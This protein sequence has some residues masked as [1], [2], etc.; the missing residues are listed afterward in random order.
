MFAL[1]EKNALAVTVNKK[2]REGLADLR[3]IVELVQASGYTSKRIQADFTV[4]RGLEYYTGPVF[5]AE[6]LSP[7]KDERGQPIR[8]GSVVSGGRYDGLVERFTGEKV[9]STGISIGVSRLLFGLQ[10]LG[11]YKESP[12][13]GPV[14]VLVLDRDCI[15]DY[16]KMTQGSARKHARRD[17]SRH[18]GMKAQMKYADR[19]DAPCVVI[20]GGDEMANGE[21]TS[22]TSS[23]ATR[24]PTRSARQSEDAG[25]RRSSRSRKAT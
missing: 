25:R 18:V 23:W 17:V 21:V 12:A 8:L 15:A 9:P 19:R 3:S 24:S 10:R 22:R 2:F 6:L 5:E 13:P 16:Q 4:V 7:I 20:Q 14:V 11:T 1:Y